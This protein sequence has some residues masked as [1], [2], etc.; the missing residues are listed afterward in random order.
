VPYVHMRQFCAAISAAMVPL[1]YS[2]ARYL[3]LS[4]PAAT[5][6]ASLILFGTRA[7][8]SRRR[9]DSR[10][11]RSISILFNQKPVDTAEIALGRLILLDPLL[12]LATSIVLWAVAWF[13][14]LRSQ[15]AAVGASYFLAL[16]RC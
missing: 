4:I 15:Y 13:R 1:M 5:L 6:A 3:T 2:A 14:S 8:A 12:L 10:P 7:K 11:D 9:H 16:W